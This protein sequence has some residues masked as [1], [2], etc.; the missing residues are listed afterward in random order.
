MARRSS[1]GGGMNLDSLMDTLTNVVGILLIILIYSLLSSTETVKRIKG[2]VDEISDEQYARMLAEAEEMRKLLAQQ[3]RSVQDDQGDYSTQRETLVA[4]WKLIE[5]LK[6]DYA[7][8]TQTKINVEDLKKQVE[9]RRTKAESLEKQ[10]SESEKLIATLKAR[11]AETPA[12]GPDRDAKIVNLP[13]P[14]PA[15]KGA[16]PVTF[17]CRGGR[18]VPVDI[19]GLQREAQQVIQKGQRAL[20]KQNQI[21]CEKLA[22]LFEKRFVGDQFCRVRIRVGGDAK[23][24]LAVEM[25]PNAGDK[26]ENIARGNQ[27]RRWIQGVDPQKFY[28]EFR[29]FSDSYDTYLAAR[30]VAAKNGILG[31]W[32]PYDGK[33]E[34]NIGLGVDLKMTC[35]GK[36]P[37]PPTPPKP[38]DPKRPPPPADVVD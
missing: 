36:K 17:L 21:D 30:N 3:D 25:R 32:I 38:G 14:R 10:I 7:K 8:L 4:K 18:I 33:A 37:P 15:P 13:D 20:L 2:F 26:T 22:Q 28:F 31:G 5:Q 29:V 34:Y 9:Q 24:Q 23:P 35:L 1:S 16:Q 6:K 12:A 11:L 19:P 27:F